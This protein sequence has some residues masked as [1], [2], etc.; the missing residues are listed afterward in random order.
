MKKLLLLTLLLSGATAFAAPAPTA[1]GDLIRATPSAPQYLAMAADAWAGVLGGVGVSA[2]IA[3]YIRQSAAND[4]AGFLNT[5]SVLAYN[6][7]ALTLYQTSAHL[8]NAFSVLQGAPVRRASSRQVL[9]VD[10]D[11]FGAFDEYDNN[12]NANFKTRTFGGVVRA[13]GFVTDHFSFGIQYAT[14]RTDTR[15]SIFSTDGTSNSVTIFAQ[16]IGRSGVFMN[17]GI[18]GGTTRWDADKT[19]AGVPDDDAYNTDFWAGEMNLGAVMQRSGF[20]IT[21]QIGAR[22][23]R[24]SADRH[25]DAAAQTFKNWWYNTLTGTA[26]V[27]VAYD[28]TMT[29][30]R[31]RPM[32]SIGGSYDAISNGTDNIR[33]SVISGDAYYMPVDAPHR[34]AMNVGVGV[35]IA[36]QNVSGGL[37][38]KM[39]ARNDYISHT[40]RLGAK[41]IF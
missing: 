9:L 18:N 28:F 4:I 31:V 14:G 3:S 25:T 41:I 38:Y 12:Q 17:M 19:V 32:I 22:Y 10:G 24:T 21:P 34:A 36:G 13:R 29:N 16:Y 35:Q 15:H 11:V 8:D 39:D 1:S 40:A 27:R 37:E 26:G 23:A 6:D 7:S 33:V 5:V 2:D 20:S 30:M